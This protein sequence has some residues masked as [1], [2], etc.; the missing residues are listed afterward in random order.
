MGEEEVGRII[1]GV[2]IGLAKKVM[3][4]ELEERMEEGFVV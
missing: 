2:G 1:G 4:E 3:D